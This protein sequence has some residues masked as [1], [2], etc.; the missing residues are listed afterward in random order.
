MRA[1]DILQQ[2]DNTLEDWTVSGDAMRSRPPGE[3][4]TA[5]RPQVWIAP[6]GAEPDDPN[7]QEVGHVTSID[8]AIGLDE[9]DF[10]DIAVELFERNWRQMQEY[11][12]HVRAEQARQAAI[13]LEAFT[14]ALT[15]VIKPAVER[16]GRSLARAQ[17]AFQH[18]PEAVDCNDCG[19][20]PPPRD[21]PAWQSPYGPPQRRR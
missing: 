2:I 1:D 16:G 8:I 18:L 10:D 21:R 20:P 14:R 13:A 15:E 11:F 12:T 9:D 4:E 3:P 6:I 5:L 19:K 7:W 17:D